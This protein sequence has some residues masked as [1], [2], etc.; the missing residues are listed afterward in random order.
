MLYC[1]WAHGQDEDEEILPDAP[2]Q[3]LPRPEQQ[4]ACSP[5]PCPPR[6]AALRCQGISLRSWSVQ[7]PGRR[8]GAYRAA[9]AWETVLGKQ[10]Y[11]AGCTRSQR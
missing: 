1:A 9:L 7:T 3:G 6:S 11:L 5:E 4:E 8:R 2:C 10:D